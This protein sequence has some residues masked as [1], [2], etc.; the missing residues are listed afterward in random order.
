MPGPH[1]GWAPWPPAPQHG[2]AVVG[3]PYDLGIDLGTTFTAAAVRCEPRP[4][5]PE[6]G[7]R[8]VGLEHGTVQVPSVL[9]VDD[10]G[11]LRVG[12]DAEERAPSAPQ[13][14][15]REFKRRLGDDTPIVVGGESF[16]ADGVAA[17]MVRWTADRVAETHGAEPRRLAVAHPAGWGAYRR[18]VFT[19]AL[20]EVGLHDVVLLTEPEAAAAAHAAAGRLPLGRTVAVYDLGGGTFDA[21]V[22]H[23]VAASP[24]YPVGLKVLGR[25]QGLEA[26]GGIDFDEAL[27]WHVCSELGGAVAALDPADPDTVRAVA[28]LRRA[29]V[30]AKETLSVDT[31]AVVDVRLPNV[32]TRVRITRGEFEEMIEPAL[33]QTVDVLGEVLDSARVAA[34]DLDGVL[35]VGGSSRIPLVARM[36]SAE[37]GRPVAVDPDPTTVVARGATWAAAAAS[38]A[39]RPAGPLSGP[40]PTPG[41]GGFPRPRTG[42]FPT[43]G[44]GGFPTPGTGG[45]PTPGTGGFP[46]PASVPFPTPG[47]G[48]FAAVPYPG[49]PGDDEPRTELIGREAALLA[50]ARAADP[51]DPM[52]TP[53]RLDLRTAH[54]AVEPVTAPIASPVPPARPT[55][56]SAAPAE[57]PLE[58]PGTPDTRRRRIALGAGAAA[59][60]VVGGAV[61]V[62]VPMI[63]NTSTS[64]ATVAA[65]TPGAP[66][67]ARPVT[68]DAGTLPAG[69][70]PAA[71]DA[72]SGTTTA[73]STSP[74]ATRAPASRVARP[75]SPVTAPRPA[76]PVAAAPAPAAVPV[77][78][79]PATTPPATT[80][81][82]TTP[83]TTTTDPNEGKSQTPPSSTPPSSTANPPAGTPSTGGTAPAAGAAAPGPTV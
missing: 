79:K 57:R 27:F 11:A 46:T 62:T 23:G 31:E 2:D 75:A 18:R 54:G 20:A 41:T 68:A 40:F 45:F 14:V 22:V 25:G 21:A 42:G 4:G 47:S 36:L 15:V 29:C 30:A 76:A 60:L 19:E 63:D 69:T 6:S 72:S 64:S 48:P 35:L 52:T 66:A 24:S 12:A 13:R 55:A 67:P 61:A 71:T 8:V 56:F 5:A 1:Q 74:A 7:V 78:Q 50:H 26:L 77:A 39:I 59:V 49:V 80:G 43:P 44:T 73:D 70:L 38:G 82:T 28:G 58:P 3:T 9:L 33:R 17:E 81:G 53:V 16:S 65:P 32:T 51:A 83:G 34:R 37:L 10:D